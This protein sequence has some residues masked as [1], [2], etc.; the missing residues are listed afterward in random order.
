MLKFIAK[1]I[2]KLFGW[3]VKGKLPELKK[4]VLIGAPHTSNWDFPLALFGA[5]GLGLRFKWFAK[6]S[7]FKGPMGLIL[8]FYG[9]IPVNRSVHSSLIDRMIEIFNS[10]DEFVLGIMPEGT[11]SKTK[12]WKSG[13]Y[14]IAIGAKVPIAFSFMDYGTKQV[15]IDGYFVPV[16]NLEKDMQ[17]IKNFYKN[18]KGKR[19]EKQ[20]EVKIKVQNNNN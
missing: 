7:I 11:R 3:K 12:Y 2:L 15:G 19:P 17:T 14:H 16:G 9:G 20:S 5:L 8:K 4:Y 6:H 13:F 1:F 18:I 10:K